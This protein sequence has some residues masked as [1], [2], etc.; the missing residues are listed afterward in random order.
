MREPR[1]GGPH[2]R[3]DEGLALLKGGARQ[4]DVAATLDV[5]AGTV[6]AWASL[7]R[8]AGE[9]AQGKRGPG[10]RKARTPAEV[11]DLKEKTIRLYL[12]NTPAKEIARSLGAS[13][14]TINGWIVQARKAGAIP[15]GL[16]VGPATGPKSPEGIERIRLGHAQR[17][18]AVEPKEFVLRNTPATQALRIAP[19]MRALAEGASLPEAEIHRRLLAL[20]LPLAEKNPALLLRAMQT[21]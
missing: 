9:L 17:G 2:P 16:R 11:R 10:P 5:P 12:L 8:A 7:L 1:T 13:V 15:T 14:N 21:K 3:R 6:A 4:I 19:R 18:A 20:A